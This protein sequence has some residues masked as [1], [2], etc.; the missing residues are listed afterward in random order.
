MWM[1]WVKFLYYLMGLFPINPLITEHINSHETCQPYWKFLILDTALPHGEAVKSLVYQKKNKIKQQH[2][3]NTLKILY[4][5]FLHFS[6][7]LYRA[8]T[9]INIY[10]MLFNLHYPRIHF[11]VW[12]YVKFLV[13]KTFFLYFVHCNIC[14]YIY[15]Y[16]ERAVLLWFFFY[17]C[18]LN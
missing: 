9:G 13:L 1:T 6:T 8:Y 15:I 10:K 11:V 17:F 4:Y 7:I 18:F 5:F 12:A 14:L 2:S 16:S 3:V